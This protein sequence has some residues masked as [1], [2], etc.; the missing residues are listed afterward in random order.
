[1][2]LNETD[3]KARRQDG[4]FCKVEQRRDQI[5]ATGLYG[6]SDDNETN[7]SNWIPSTLEFSTLEF[8]TLE[9]STLEMSTM[10]TRTGNN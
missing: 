3:T 2:A 4:R 6:V 9:L 10:I 5:Q 1:M 8:S 7:P